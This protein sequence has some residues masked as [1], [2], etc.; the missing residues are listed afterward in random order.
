MKITYIALA[1]LPTEKA[2]GLQIVK[3]IEALVRYGNSVELLIPNRKNTINVDLFAFYGI[4]KC[5]TVKKLRCWDAVRW[6][7][8]KTVGF[9]FLM[10]SFVAA[11]VTEVLRNRS[12]EIVY[13]TREWLVALVLSY[14]TPQIFYEVHTMPTHGNWLHRLA[15]RRCR[16]IVTISDGLKTALIEQ[17]I[18]EKKIMI[19]P[20][21]VDLEKFSL[22]ESP[23]ECRH[24][25]GLPLDKK[26]VV[27][28]GHLYAWKGAD[29][30]AEAAEHLSPGVQVYLVGG[31]VED[32][33]RFRKRY[34][35][36]KLHTIGWQ[37]PQLIPYWLKAADVL[38][39]PNSGQTLISKF[40]TSPLK[41]FEY[42]ASGRPIVAARLPSIMEVVNDSIVTWFEPDNN[43][44]LA[45]SIGVVLHNLTALEQAA[46]TGKKL[47]IEKF[48]WDER[49]RKIANFLQIPYGRGYKV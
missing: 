5:F 41:L 44:S 4:K 37:E 28:T 17:G 3:T 11:V 39:L 47:V 14:C 34:H 45:Q 36:N 15:W 30:L 12:H 42:L 35:S 9:F 22:A 43:V 23:V 13:Y 38:I 49:A 29:V 16:G 40:Y 48:T 1:R 20:D 8:L 21:G 2:H 26:I 24:K 6:P 33:A 19:A 46:Q 27:Y 10:I 18:S 31:T 7:V 32:V 25:L